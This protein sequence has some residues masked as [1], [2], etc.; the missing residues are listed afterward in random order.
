M[1]GHRR[2]PGEQ[3]VDPGQADDDH[4]AGELLRTILGSVAEGVFAIDESGT[5]VFT[6]QGFADL[7]GH[8]PAD[9]AG[10]PLSTVVPKENARY[11]ALTDALG[12]DG[13]RSLDRACVDIPA[14]HSDGRRLYL[15]VSF[16]ARESDGGTLVIG[17]V[18]DAASSRDKEQAGGGQ[19]EQT[20]PPA[21]QTRRPAA[22]RGEPGRQHQNGAETAQDDREPEMEQYERIIETID[23]GIYVLDEN[24]TITNVNEA[25]VSMTGYSRAELLGSHAS[26]L[27]SDDL[28]QQAATL[29]AEMHN[30]R[31][32]TAT[33]VSE[34]VTKD[35]EPVPIETRFS[36]YPFADDSYGQLGV[37]R[38]ISDRKQV[39]ATLR[40]LHRATRELLA[41]DAKIDVCKLVVD[42]ATDVLDLDGTAIYRIDPDENVLRPTASSNGT[43]EFARSLPVLAPDGSL[44][45]RVF[46]EGEAELIGSGGAGEAATEFP[47]DSGLCVPL[48]DHG[49]F[50]AATGDR[51]TID[52]DTKTLV[53]LLAASAEDALSRL[54]REIDV[55]ERD[56]RLEEQNRRLRQLNQVNAIIREID[57]SLVE[58]ESI[59]EIGDAVCD[60]LVASDR[61][62]FAWFGES[63]TAEETITPRSWA[64]DGLGYLDDVG[65][66]LADPREPAATAIVSG[67]Q[68]VITDVT[69]DLGDGRWRKAA[70]AREYQ[71]AISIPLTDGDIT[72]GVLTVYATEPGAFD[73][74]QTVFAE[75]GET[76]ANAMN[77]VLT[78][79]ALLTDSHTE[80]GVR[81]AASDTVLQRIARRAGGPIEIEDVVPQ[82]EDGTRLFFVTGDTNPEA[83]QAT[84]EE[85]VAV[86]TVSLVA[87]REESCL[88]EAV[89]TGQ[90]L[91][92]TVVDR[93]AMVRTLT[94]S[95]DELRLDVE[96]PDE[97]NV[98]GFVSFLKSEFEGV[99]LVSKTDRDRPLRT[100]TEFQYEF[101]NRLTDRQLEVLRVAYLRGFFEWPRESTGQEIADSLDVSQPTVNRHLRTCQRKLFTLLFEE[102]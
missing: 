44:P 70:F 78:R 1:D 36:L 12:A 68:Q 62:A 29:S 73:D 89:V 53:G 34:I 5:V 23:D 99:E 75:L 46:V 65:L 83:V 64:G 2:D 7:L 95:E 20:R 96:V 39:E 13:G 60:R 40:A 50:V 85:S 43:G 17:T 72:H 26:L 3:P 11:H 100:P 14:V 27:A 94:V 91:V 90:T 55:Q 28:L 101:E 74:K 102:S 10:E 49:V 93:G 33:I 71:S 35:G 37:V 25:V 66:S 52:D 82:A 86:E 19:H 58:A 22:G 63:D 30:S 84:Q 38:D 45:W 92:T 79:R 56:R 41:V 61:F 67:T 47:V 18:R 59:D 21:R 88:F 69:A 42:T 98:R 81:I 6:N 76:I 8:E 87:Q 16:T 80:L 31:R 9:L 48:D 54:D 51:E 24:F 4:T 57:Q 15:S 77:A 32:E 97:S